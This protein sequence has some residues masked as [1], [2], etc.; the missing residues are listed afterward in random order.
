MTWELL[1]LHRLYDQPTEAAVLYAILE[2]PVP[3]VSSVRPG[4]GPLWD[5]FVDKALAR[6]GANPPRNGNGRGSGG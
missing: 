2:K 5:P 4:L 1:A 3:A 6:Y